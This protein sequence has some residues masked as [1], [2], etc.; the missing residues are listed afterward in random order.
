MCTLVVLLF[1]ALYSE[2]IKEYL[3]AWDRLEENL[4]RRLIEKVKVR[5]MVEVEFVL[6]AGVEVTEIL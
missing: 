4:F 5:S 3:I 1:C 2:G 6:K